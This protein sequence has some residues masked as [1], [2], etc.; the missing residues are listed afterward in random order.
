MIEIILLNYLN[1][2]LDVPVYMEKQEKTVQR[3]ILLEKIGS[4]TTNYINTSTIAIQSHAESLYQSALLNEEVKKAMSNIVILDSISKVK[5]E[6]D[7]NYTDT[8]KKQYRYHAIYE[9]VHY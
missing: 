8:N 7:Y 5:L 2:V 9:L 3:Y 1:S 6:N 4:S